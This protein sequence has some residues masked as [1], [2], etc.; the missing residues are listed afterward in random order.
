MPSNV[1]DPTLSWGVWGEPCP[2]F[3]LRFS[4]PVLLRFGESE[5]AFEGGENFSGILGGRTFTEMSC[6]NAMLVSL[7]RCVAHRGWPKAPAASLTVM[8]WL[9]LLAAVLQQH[10]E[11]WVS[12]DLWPPPREPRTDGQ[13]SVVLKQPF[14]HPGL[15]VLA[16]ILGQ[17]PGP[18]VGKPSSIGLWARICAQ[19][20]SGS[21]PKYAH[22]DSCSGV[23]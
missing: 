2:K 5:F 20:G 23:Q 11:G 18:V 22:Y 6:V 17:L 19:T 4:R 14:P 7:S 15:S 21:V 16:P 10:L 12:A 13:L 3:L 9:G 1:Q 8:R